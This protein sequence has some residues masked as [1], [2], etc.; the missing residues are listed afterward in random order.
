MTE[1]KISLEHMVE[2]KNTHSQD[3]NDTAWFEVAI[4]I[5]ERLER[6]IEHLEEIEGAMITEALS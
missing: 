2:L 3:P 6:I 5:A 1:I 4:G